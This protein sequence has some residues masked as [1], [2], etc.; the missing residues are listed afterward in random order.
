MCL[1]YRL[2]KKNN[3]NSKKDSEMKVLNLFSGTR[4]WSKVQRPMGWT[5]WDLDNNPKC[6]MDIDVNILDWD[7]IA[8]AVENNIKPGDLRLI[9]ASPPCTSYS[10]ANPL[11]GDRLEQR[12]LEGDKLVQRTLDIIDYFKP[13]YWVIENPAY[14]ALRNRKVVEGVHSVVVCYCRYGYKIKKA[15]RLFTNIEA[16]EDRPCLGQKKGGCPACYRDEVTGR[17]KHEK[18]YAAKT[19]ERWVT[20]NEVLSMPPALCKSVMTLAASKN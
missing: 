19:T 3:S 13:K 4:S 6:M 17:W 8:W 9:T 10:Q 5:A 15:T 2:T 12:R 14:G 7:Y 18:T 1:E 16:L 20:Y 11:T